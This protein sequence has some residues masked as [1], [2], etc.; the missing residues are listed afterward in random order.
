VEGQ[1]RTLVYLRLIALLVALA[2]AAGAVLFLLTRD[3]KY[4]RVSVALA[5]YAVVLA[6]IGFLLLAVERIT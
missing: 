1:H 2:I 5:K 3:R 4:L 6:L